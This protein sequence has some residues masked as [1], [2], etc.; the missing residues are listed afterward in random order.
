M[1]AIGENRSLGNLEEG[2][3]Q[4]RHTVFPLSTS[5]VP[6]VKL[7]GFVHG[8]SFRFQNLNTR[9]VSDVENSLQRKL[10]TSANLGAPSLL[11][12][13]HSRSQGQKLLLRQRRHGFPWGTIAPYREQIAGPCFQYNWQ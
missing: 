2:K 1:T 10:V 12:F 3:H 5:P 9:T 8:I 13:S 6:S 4:R 11:H 7:A